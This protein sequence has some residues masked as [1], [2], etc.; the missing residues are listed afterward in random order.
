[1]VTKHKQYSRVKSEWPL[2]QNRIDRYMDLVITRGTFSV[3]QVI[4]TI[5]A[6]MPCVVMRDM[7]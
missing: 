1:M 3:E 6:V 2:R 4:I 7:S 5:H